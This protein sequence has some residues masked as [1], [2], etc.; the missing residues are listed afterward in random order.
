MRAL[1]AVRDKDKR[2]AQAVEI[3]CRQAKKFIGAYAAIMGGLDALVFSG[4]IGENSPEIRAEICAGLE[5]LGIEIYEYLNRRNS[6]EISRRNGRVVVSVI[7][8]DE[9]WVMAKIV[10]EKLGR[11]KS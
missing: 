6:G 7:P 9:E 4:G 11:K 8:T 10:W 1:L 2:A 5:F 3:F